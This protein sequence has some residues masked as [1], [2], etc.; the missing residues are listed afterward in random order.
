MS[1]SLDDLGPL[2]AVNPRDDLYLAARRSM[3]AK[4]LEVKQVHGLSTAEYCNAL[5]YILG[6]A[7][8]EAMTIERSQAQ[9]KLE[10]EAEER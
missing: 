9:R 2:P 3:L 7:T 5:S 1:D 10:K 8:H 4:L 6:L